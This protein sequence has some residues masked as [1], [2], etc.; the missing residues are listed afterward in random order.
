MN[1][2]INLFV[3]DKVVWGL[4]FVLCTISLVEVFSATSTLTYKSGN[5]WMPF[6][7]H[8]VYVGT[9]IV[10]A[11]VVSHIKYN[12]WKAT[13][14][15]LILIS[16]AF[17]ISAFFE[18]SINGA[19]RWSDAIIGIRFQPSEIAKLALVIATAALLSNGQEDD[20]VNK[21]HLKIILVT[22]GIICSLI[23]VNDFSTAI[24]L[25]ATIFIMLIIGRV[26]TSNLFKLGSILAGSVFIFVAII[27]VTPKET[28]EQIPILSRGSTWK[29]R[30]NSFMEDN[31]TLDFTKDAQKI[32]AK[33]AIA[34]SNIIGKPFNSVQR[35]FLSQAY[36]DFIYAII[37]EE[38]GLL[39]GTIVTLLYLYLMM[40][41]MKIGRMCKG[42]FGTYVVMGLSTMIVFQALCNMCVAVGIGPVTGQTLPLI[43]RGGTSIVINS[44]AI[45]I[46]LSVSRFNKQYLEAK[47]KKDKND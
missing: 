10:A 20:G 3:G 7:H 39:G 45:G 35:D 18:E 24:L 40:R 21:Q 41:A 4:Y 34:S 1:R 19:N 30:L 44:I 26:K 17:L 36:S 37:I 28:L 22:T 12:W 14:F 47:I 27:Y 31:K 6:I 25:G 33:I 43:S 32:H 46:I 13:P 42:D 23:I 38:L 11:I 5:Y 29:S 8:A 16:I 2:K 9:G 15:A